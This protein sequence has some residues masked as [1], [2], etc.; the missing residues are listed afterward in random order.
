MNG[1]EVL[2]N[3]EASKYVEHFTENT[4]DVCYYAYYA[5]M[6]DALTNLDIII[7]NTGTMLYDEY[8]KLPEKQ[9]PNE[10][11]LEKLKELIS[12]ITKE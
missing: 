12:V 5:G 8:K 10:L 1:I 3:K 4:K 11:V 2:C 7:K 6:Q 9:R